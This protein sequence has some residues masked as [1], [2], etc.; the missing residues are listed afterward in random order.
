MRKT[1][2]PKNWIM[3]LPFIKRVPCFAHT[4]QLIVAKF[5]QVIQF[6]KVLKNAHAVVSKVNKS[7]RATE[8]LVA[9]CNKKLITDCR[10]RWSSTYLLVERLLEVR[11]SLTSVLEEFEWDNLAAS[12][13]KS[14]EKIYKL[15]K[16][17]AQYTT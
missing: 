5:D 12:E 14:L 13:W 1:L 9:L 6:K 7:T 15:L 17:F 16:P 10:T 11:S 4:L 3:M 2:H 8:K